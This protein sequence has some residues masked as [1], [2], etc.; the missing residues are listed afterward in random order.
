[1]ADLEDSAENVGVCSVGLTGGASALTAMRAWRQ[2]R[3]I[4]VREKG[5][6]RVERSAGDR[7]AR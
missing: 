6:R 3:E 1:M 7:R 5:K 2:S 4:T